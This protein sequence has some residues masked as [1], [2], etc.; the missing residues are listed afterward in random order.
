M[1]TAAGYSI[2][3]FF[4]RFTEA[5]IRDLAGIEILSEVSRVD[6][7][8]ENKYF[9]YIHNNLAHS[10]YAVNKEGVIVKEGFPVPGIENAENT[11]AAVYSAK[12]TLDVLIDWF[13]WMKKEGVYDNT[14]IYIFSDHGNWFCDSDLPELTDITYDTLDDDRSHAN[15]LVLTKPLAGSGELKI[16][17]LYIHSSDLPAMLSTD[18][19]LP[20]IFSLDPRTNPDNQ[21]R[22][23][24][25]FTPSYKKN[26]YNLYY[27]SGSIFDKDAWSMTLP[28]K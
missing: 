6:T 27:V 26:K 28:E 23:R 2:K 3:K 7:E 9:L 1:I 8:P 24:F 21:N 13:S 25:Y 15:T 18:T 17:P 5:A 22:V 10:P 20:N 16:D 12:K 11:V 19:G 14:V 4:I